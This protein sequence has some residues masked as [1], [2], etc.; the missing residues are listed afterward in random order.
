M[1]LRG[2]AF[3]LVA[4]R[5]LERPITD[6]YR[7]A[8]DTLWWRKLDSIAKQIGQYLLN[9]ELVRAQNGKPLRKLRDDLHLRLLGGW[10]HGLQRR[11]HDRRHAYAG[12]P[13]GKLAGVRFAD[14]ENVF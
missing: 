12:Q 2:N 5:A 14:E 7:K 3:A 6:A 9:T 13:Q 10:L 8:N 11:F 1:V 4:Y